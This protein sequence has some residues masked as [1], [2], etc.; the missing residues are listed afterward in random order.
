VWHEAC[1][2]RYARTAESIT[3]TFKCPQCKQEHNVD[4]LNDWDAA[5]VIERLFPEDDYHPED[6]SSA[7]SDASASEGESVSSDDEDS[8]ND[9]PPIPKRKTRSNPSNHDDCRRLTRSTTNS[10]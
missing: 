10:S 7:S 6:E 9:D 3:N 5:V 4:D 2:Y 1:I 8:S